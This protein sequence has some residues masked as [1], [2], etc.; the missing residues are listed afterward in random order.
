MDYGS[1]PRLA[2]AFDGSYA[3][4]E[5]LEKDIHRL[6]ADS[7]A[8]VHDREHAQAVRKGFQTVNSAESVYERD[9]RSFEPTHV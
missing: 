3:V 4:D 9:Y 7:R 8:G 6:P 2:Q 1:L 5:P